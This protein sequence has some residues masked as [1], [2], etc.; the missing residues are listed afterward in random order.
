MQCHLNVNVPAQ[1]TCCWRGRMRA[2]CRAHLECWCLC[3]LW[4][5][6]HGLTSHLKWVAQVRCIRP[7][8]H[9]LVHS[10]D[11][12]IRPARSCTAPRHGTVHGL[13][14][15]SHVSLFAA[16][17]YHHSSTLL[18]HHLAPCRCLSSRVSNWSSPSITHGPVNRKSN[19]ANHPNCPWISILKRNREKR[20][21]KSQR[22]LGAKDLPEVFASINCTP[23]LRFPLRSST[24]ALVVALLGL[25]TRQVEFVLLPDMTKCSTQA[26]AESNYN[27]E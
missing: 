20:W 14:A 6:R 7:T 18:S 21:N 12:V 1:G 3:L 24:P 13:C 22:S 4:L 11:S 27:K 17:I 23:A 8:R 9:S 26:M 25:I 15:G 10:T 2:Q 19:G 16:H 5:P